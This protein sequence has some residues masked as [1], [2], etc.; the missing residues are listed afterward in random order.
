MNENDIVF[1]TYKVNDRDA[2]ACLYKNFKPQSMDII[3]ADY[4]QIQKIFNDTVFDIDKW[5]TTFINIRFKDES[6]NKYHVVKWS[7]FDP[8][9][10]ELIETEN[11]TF[12]TNIQ[13]IIR[14]GKAPGVVSKGLDRGSAFHKGKVDEGAITDLLDRS[15]PKA[16]ERIKERQAR[17]GHAFTKNDTNRT[18]LRRKKK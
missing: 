14:E 7:N 17:T 2:Y 16:E 9:K 4:N 3:D 5:E 15:L 18:I 6:K 8:R 10:M 11:E 12:K 13:D 1:Y